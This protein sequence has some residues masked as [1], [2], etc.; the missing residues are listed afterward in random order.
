MKV[1]IGGRLSDSIQ[2]IKNLNNK[3]LDTLNNGGTLPFNLVDSTQLTNGFSNYELIEAEYLLSKE[4]SE[5]WKQQ[6]YA[7]IKLLLKS[8]RE[9]A[10]FLKVRN[11]T[12]LKKLY[13]WGIIVVGVDEHGK[14]KISERLLDVEKMF[15]GII[16]K[17][18][19]DGAS[20]ILSVFDMVDFESK[21]NYMI[22]SKD[23]YMAEKVV[24]RIKSVQ[25]REQYK[26]LIVM[27]RLI[28]KEMYTHPDFNKRDLE[29]WGY[30]VLEFHQNS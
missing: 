15:K 4:N 30:V 21:Y 5:I 3:V 29:V 24:R 11:R 28:A 7:N 13:E 8:A 9:I 10:Q 17:N 26:E 18:A 14:V 6:R 12:N 23:N 27:Q 25:K 19:L 2:Q 16:T 1:I 20:S 22:T